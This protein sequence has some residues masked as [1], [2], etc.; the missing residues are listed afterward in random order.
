LRARPLSPPCR[1]AVCPAGHDDVKGRKKTMT[2]P[3]TGAMRPLLFP[4]DLQFWYETLR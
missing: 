1:L 2:T 4:D 3:D